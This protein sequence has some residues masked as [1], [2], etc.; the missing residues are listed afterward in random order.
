MI[1]GVLSRDDLLV[2]LTEYLETYFEVPAEDILPNANLYKDLDL[3]SIDAVDL[4][5]KLQELT[6][7]KIAPEEFKTVQTVGDV[8]DRLHDLVSKKA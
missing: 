4:M 2:K 1:D 3:D 6:E 8:V 5:I 7:Q